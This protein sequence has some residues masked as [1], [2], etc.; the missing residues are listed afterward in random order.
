[1]PS[2]STARQPGMVQSP[3]THADALRP[4]HSL[5]IMSPVI[6]SLTVLVGVALMAGCWGGPNHR[7]GIVEG[8]LAPCPSS[9][10]CVHTGMRHPDGTKGMFADTRVPRA[11]LMELISVV[12]QATPRTTII[13]QDGDYL[14]A[15][16][17]SR[18][19][20]FVDDLEIVISFDNEVIIRSASRVGRGDMGVN[21][22]RVEDLRVRLQAAGAIR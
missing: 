7:L 22:A 11:E 20:R 15:E 1:M 5:E 12:V 21:A 16:M 4:L 18:I 17:T 8:S 19:F 10:N 3:F 9:P 6:R 13:A 14:H 2:S